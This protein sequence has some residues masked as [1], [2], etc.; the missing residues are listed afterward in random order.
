[1]G[2][3]RPPA[4]PR[5]PLGLPRLA[6]DIRHSHGYNWGREGRDRSAMAS[7]LPFIGRRHIC[8]PLAPAVP[9]GAQER[10][11]APACASESASVSR[12]RR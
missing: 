2:A 9:I 5:I 8:L 1:M 11:D 7:R 6:V 4:Y 3:Q 12:W 10:I